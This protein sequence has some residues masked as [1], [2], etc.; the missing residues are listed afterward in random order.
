MEFLVMSI[1]HGWQLAPI[2]QVTVTR[3]NAE[4]AARLETLLRRIIADRRVDL[5]CEECN[6]CY[7]SVGQRI[8]YE[9]DPRIPWRNIVMTSQERLEAGV[10]EALL[11]RP[12]DT[13]E[14]PPDS[15][16]FQTIHH[17]IPHD[18]TRERFFANASIQAGNGIGARSVLVLC[19]D[20]HTDF[21][22]RI[23]EESKFKA[24]VNHELIF[25]KDWVA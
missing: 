25:R 13:V 17:R 8:A 23:L 15:G 7:V 18:D 20:M 10:Y 9:H 4:N 1:D 6:P 21:V 19:G 24:E 2:P 12:Y 14:I 3:E 16:N 22:R 5:I 11:D